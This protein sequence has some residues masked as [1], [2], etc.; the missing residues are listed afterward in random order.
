MPD[1]LSIEML[2][3]EYGDCLW[4]E[5][6]SDREVHRLLIDGGP[7]DT[8][9]L[10]RQ[11]IEPLTPAQFD[12][13]VVSHLDADHIGGIVGFISSETSPVVFHD[14]W[15]NGYQHLPTAPPRDFAQAD[16][17][18]Q[19]LNG[20]SGNLK[21]G[22]NV[23]W[24]GRAVVRSDD[25]PVSATSLASLP[26]KE[27]PWGLRITL[28][29]PTPKRLAALW[30]GWDA[31]MREVQ[32][33]QS[34]TQPYQQRGRSLELL[35]DLAQL[36][37]THSTRDNTPPNGSSIAFLLEYGGKSCLFAADAFA[38]VLYPALATLAQSRGV[39]R[40]EIDAFKIPHH[41]SQANV[42]PQLFEFVRARH[43]LVSTSG[44]RFEHPHDAAMARIIT[45]GGPGQ[46]IWF[47]Y[48][49]DRTARWGQKSLLDRYQYQVEYP[50]SN[51][52]GIT[53]TL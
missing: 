47:N 33:G 6:R 20:Q 5:C 53:L 9:S 22:W 2:P 21:L 19:A 3:A 25:D 48:H 52:A 45:L 39:K 28:L 1:Q 38:T 35:P 50:A 7:P 46:T 31:Y 4:V 34:S 42:L 17:L 27:T 32:A 36:A 8:A 18:T 49:S 13:L 44:A 37:A 26:V 23:A 11:R 15:F 40:L 30:R 41:G 12:L 43:Y 10:L 24:Q 14:V 29:S 16:A 51:T